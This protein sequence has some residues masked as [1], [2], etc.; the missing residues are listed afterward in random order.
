M[1]PII[2][3][4]GPVTLYTYGL[5]VATGF[6]TTMSYMAYR[7]KKEGIDP[8]IALDLG[9]YMAIGAIG[10]ARILYIIV[11]YHDYLNAPLNVFKV[12][13]GGLV[14]YGGVIGSCALGFWYVRKQK[15]IFGTMADIAAPGIALGHA[16]GRWGCFAAGC[17]YG[18]PTDS[19]IGVTFRNVDSLAPR[20][21]P[22]Y[23]TQIMESVLE[24]FIFFILVY[25]VR[26]RKK[27]RGQLFLTWVLLYAVGRFILEFFRGDQRGYIIQNEL[28]TSQGVAIAIFA[29][30]L[31]VFLRSL[32]KAE[33]NR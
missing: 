20:G 1:F 6:L 11:N 24:L 15:L 10:G 9:F 3:K 32:R 33:K 25:F 22:I 12:W 28:S 23:P 4:I 30:G 27:F 18:R 29:L 5:L 26:P 8:Q 13:E 31:V 2:L 19:W 16:I 14:F 21:V 7:A 17:C